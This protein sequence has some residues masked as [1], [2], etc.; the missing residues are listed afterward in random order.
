MSAGPRSLKALGEKP[1]LPLGASGD[2]GVPGLV[3][4]SFQSPRPLAGGLSH[5]MS[6]HDAIISFMRQPG[7][8]AGAQIK[9]CFWVCECVSS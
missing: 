5:C 1:S 7:W 2:R 8:A 9:H 3:A 6:S 4:T